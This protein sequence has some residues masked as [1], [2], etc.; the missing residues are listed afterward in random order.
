VA[1]AAGSVGKGMKG[2]GAL[3]IVSVF[4]VQV[5]KLLPEHHVRMTDSGE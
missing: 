1:S 4:D 5:I 3:K 2:T